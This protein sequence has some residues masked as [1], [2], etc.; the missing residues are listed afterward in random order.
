[1]KNGIPCLVPKDGKILDLE[2]E[3]RPEDAA[4]SSKKQ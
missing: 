3:S 2:D 4:E 1:M